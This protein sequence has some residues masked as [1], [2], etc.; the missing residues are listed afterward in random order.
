M[1]HQLG[2]RSC[3]TIGSRKPMLRREWRR[4][5]VSCC[6][7]L[8]LLHLRWGSQGLLL[9]LKWGTRGLLLQPLIDTNRQ[10]LRLLWGP[11]CRLLL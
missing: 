7:D 1:L 4:G 8:L 3:G 2:D 9:R 6:C 10:L 11:G 5:L